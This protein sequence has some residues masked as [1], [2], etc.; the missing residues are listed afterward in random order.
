MPHCQLVGAFETPTNQPA[1]FPSEQRGYLVGAHGWLRWVGG[2][3]FGVFPTPHPA[4]LHDIVGWSWTALPAGASP[5][6]VT[7]TCSSGFPPFTTS[8]SFWLSCPTQPAP[9]MLSLL[10]YAAWTGPLSSGT[11][12]IGRVDLRGCALP[13]AQS[14][15]YDLYGLA[16][17]E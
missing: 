9:G 11:D 5:L 4:K 15:A 14:Q 10:V 17:D 6:T 16:P 8:L 12:N 13:S 1:C 3:A 2:Q 7:C